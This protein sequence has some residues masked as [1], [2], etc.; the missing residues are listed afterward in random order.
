M[1]DFEIDDIRPVVIQDERPFFILKL[2]SG[3]KSIFLS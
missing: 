2:R 3:G 1:V